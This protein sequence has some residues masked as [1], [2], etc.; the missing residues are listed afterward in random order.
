VRTNGRVVEVR[1]F[2]G[3]TRWLEGQPR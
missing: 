2:T 1:A 3:R